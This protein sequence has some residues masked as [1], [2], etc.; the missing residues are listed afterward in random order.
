MET[1]NSVNMMDKS[2]LTTQDKEQI[3]VGT[4][5]YCNSVIQKLNEQYNGQHKLR[6]LFET[7]TTYYNMINLASKITGAGISMLNENVDTFIADNNFVKMNEHQNNYAYFKKVRSFLNGFETSIQ[8]NLNESLVIK[9]PTIRPLGGGRL[10]SENAQSQISNI[11]TFKKQ[12]NKYI[13]ELENNNDTDNYT[14]QVI[15]VKIF[16]NKPLFVYGFNIANSLMFQ[17]EICNKFNKN[18]DELLMILFEKSEKYLMFI[19][20][21]DII[22]Y[23]INDDEL[24]KMNLT[25]RIDTSNI[26]CCIGDNISRNVL[27]LYHKTSDLKFTDN[28]Y[29][30]VA[31]SE[32]L[33]KFKSSSGIIK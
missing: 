11:D 13:V 15:S 30:D 23:S 26:I 24:K 5:L 17:Q 31:Q 19:F 32:Y 8:Q 18:S 2:S 14:S 22:T 1:Y 12:L 29:H 33:N 21:N 4:I 25:F 10:E 7:D 28:L 3:I 6:K 20:K 9:T 16:L 27:I